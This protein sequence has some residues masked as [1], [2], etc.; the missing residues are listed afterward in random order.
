MALLPVKYFC[1]N[2][3]SFCVSQ[4]SWGSLD[5]LN[6]I[7]LTLGDITRFKTVYLFHKMMNFDQNIEQ[8][9][10]VFYI[11]ELGHSATVGMA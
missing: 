8:L 11:L 10:N 5:C 9:P 4:S 1:S 3:A 7:T 2:K 6:L